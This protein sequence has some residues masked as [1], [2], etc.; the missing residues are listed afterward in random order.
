MVISLLCNRLFFPRLSARGH[1]REEPLGGQRSIRPSTGARP[2][3][4]QGRSPAS[5]T[6]TP[7]PSSIPNASLPT[8]GIEAA[9]ARERELDAMA[10]ATPLDQAPRNVVSLADLTSARRGEPWLPSDATHADSAQQTAG[11][12]TPNAFIH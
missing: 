11:L 10:R 2:T 7:V 4:V 1:S 8:P 9:E 12:Q 3:V 5:L 6:R